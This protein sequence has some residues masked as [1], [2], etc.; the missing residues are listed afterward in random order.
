MYL[1]CDSDV[2]CAN[3]HV[4]NSCLTGVITIKCENLFRVLVFEAECGCKAVVRAL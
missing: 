2:H 4:L 1:E 3:W